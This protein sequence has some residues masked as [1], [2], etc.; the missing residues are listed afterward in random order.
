MSH[1]THIHESWSWHTHTWVMTHTYMSHDTHIHESWH[2]YAWGMPHTYWSQSNTWVTSPH[3]CMNNTFRCDSCIWLTSVCVWHASC[4]IAVWII[5]FTCVKCSHA[6]A[7]LCAPVWVKRYESHR[8]C[9]RACDTSPM[10]PCVWNTNVLTCLK[11]SHLYQILSSRVCV[12]CHQ[13]SHIAT[14]PTCVTHD[15]CSHACETLMLCSHV[16]NTLRVTSPMF[17]CVCTAHVLVCLKCCVLLCGWNATSH[18]AY[19]L[20]CATHHLCSYVCD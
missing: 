15:L 17:S 7:M 9:S 12:K 10:F 5:H 20:A 2:T 8:L 11:S 16:S 13:S 3:C 6:S 18:I 14:V 19:V 4:R 1:D